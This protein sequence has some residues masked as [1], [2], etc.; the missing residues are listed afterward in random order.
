M[1]RLIHITNQFVL[2]PASTMIATKSKTHGVKI[3]QKVLIQ[4][5]LDSSM[6]MAQEGS[7]I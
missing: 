6:L 5:K 1:Q 3:D 2:G 4:L 7:K